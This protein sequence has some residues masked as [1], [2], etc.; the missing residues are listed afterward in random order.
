MIPA[1]FANSRHITW[2]GDKKLLKNTGHTPGDVYL[3]DDYE[4]YIADEDRDHCISIR[5]FEQPYAED[6]HELDR[7]LEVIRGIHQRGLD[8]LESRPGTEKKDQ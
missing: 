5:Q 3:V 7:I 4:G 6:D 8:Y 2:Q 1:W